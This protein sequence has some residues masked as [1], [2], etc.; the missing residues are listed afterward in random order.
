MK[1][2]KRLFFLTVFFLILSPAY[3]SHPFVKNFYRDIYKSGA[4]NWAIVQD[5]NNSMCFANNSGLLV[6][7]GRKWTTTPIKNGTNVRSL[8]Y[9]SDGRI[10]ASTFNE[11]GYFRKENKK[12]I[13]Y[14]LSSKLDINKQE[15]N[16]IYS[17]IEGDKVIYFQGGKNVYIYNRKTIDKVSM[18]TR[19]DKA[20]FVNNVLFVA[21]SQA[22]IFMLTGKQFTKIP[23]SE[24][25]INKKVCAII[26]IDNQKILFV[27]SLNGVYSFDGITVSPYKTGIDKFLMENEVFCAVKN[28]NK[29]VYGTVQRGIAITDLHDKSVT[30]INTFNGLQNN[31]VLSMGFDNQLNLWLGLYNGIDYILLNNPIQNLFG[32]NNLVGSG[33]AFCLKNKTLYMGTNQGLYVTNYPPPNNLFPSEMKPIKGM[34]GQVWCLTEVNGTLFCGTERGAFIIE[35]G[36]IKQI[37][38]LLGTWNFKP[39]RNHPDLIFGSCYQGLFV[40]RKIGMQWKFSHI[41]K[42][43]FVES[44]PM[45]EEDDDETIWFSHWQK[46]MFRIKLNA[47]KDSIENVTLYNNKG[48]PTTKNNTVFRINNRL[49]FSSESGFY[50]YDH[51]TDKIIPFT[52]W[53]YLFNKKPAYMRVHEGMKGDLWFISGK[54]IGLASKKP[55]NNYQ[56]DSLSYRILQP[57]LIPGFEHLN[58]INSDNAII[59]TENGFSLINLHLTKNSN[60]CFKVY[61]CNTTIT[62][63]EGNDII[64]KTKSTYSHNQNSLKFEFAAP[65]YR[66]DG[67]VQY[68]CKLENFDQNWSVFSS[69]NIKEYTKLPKGHYVFKVIAKNILEGKEAECSYSFEILPAWYETTL[70]LIIY[71][72]FVFVILTIIFIFLEKRSKKKVQEMEQKKEIELTIQKQHYE[73]DA[74]EKKRKIRELMNQQLQ[75]E[76][77]HKSQELANSTMNLIR[78]NEMLMDIVDT[79]SKT[80]DDFR[81][82][83]DFNFVISRLGKLE[84]H[85]KQNIENDDS[86]K[87][88]EENFDLVYENY[89]KRLGDAFPRLNTSDKKLCA[90]LKMDL[91]SKDIAPLLNTTVRSVETSRYRLRKKLYLDRDTN[92]TNFLQ[93]F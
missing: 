68:S 64:F 75:H 1:E 8:L 27:T 14:S 49:I 86:W 17:I 43:N 92:L 40:L 46:G 84:K 82:N 87:M 60:S 34:E 79:L 23:G 2:L 78:K 21:C 7:D 83:S 25:L 59:N 48:F 11:F 67:L 62:N 91:S 50:V 5:K 57:K 37:L 76:L 73:V 45:F 74:S 30:Y 52:E 72:F 41:I 19:I 69:N 15:S 36:K 20:A 28:N 54:F 61:I 13:Y 51:K 88:F 3:S 53:D 85:I 4:Q 31:T 29:L 56:M 18:F 65:E 80:G 32:I 71:V 35:S 42:G 16:R 63:T 66:A 70:S 47:K 38:G 6:F 39:F 58:Y 81:H 90:Y 93:S 89:L 12:Y 10:Y 55:G 24:I 33:Y 77:K 22:G 26:P 44:S 9:N